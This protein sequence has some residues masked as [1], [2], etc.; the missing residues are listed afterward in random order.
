MQGLAKQN[1]LF[2]IGRGEK[3]EQGRVGQ[4]FEGLG[5]I[6][7]D[8]VGPPRAFH[9]ARVLSSAGEDGPF[10]FLSRSGAPMRRGLRA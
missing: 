2:I 1:A 8:H 7:S 4:G 9:T 3:R 10:S 5:G 6:S